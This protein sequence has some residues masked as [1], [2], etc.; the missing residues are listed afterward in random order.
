M[1]I[2]SLLEISV[3]SIRKYKKLIDSHDSSKEYGSDIVNA[4]NTLGENIEALSE[5]VEEIFNSDKKYQSLFE[6]DDIQDSISNWLNSTFTE[7]EDLKKQK[8]CEEK[9]ALAYEW[10]FEV[11]LFTTDD[12]DIKSKITLNSNGISLVKNTKDLSDKLKEGS[13]VLLKI[14]SEGKVE[15]M[16]LVVEEIIDDYIYSYLG[17]AENEHD[18]IIYPRECIFKI[19]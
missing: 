13:K 8:R 3:D 4:Y 17:D 14:K 10:L 16:F 2:V 12:E 5:E 7:Y 18:L 9:V 15:E 6:D 11:M 19:K 1:S